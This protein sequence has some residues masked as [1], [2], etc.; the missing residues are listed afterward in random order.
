MPLTKAATSRVIG[1]WSGDVEKAFASTLVLTASV[2]LLNT[3]YRKKRKE[4]DKVTMGVLQFEGQSG[5]ANSGSAFSTDTL[6]SFRRKYLIVHCLASFADLI[7]V[8]RDMN[9]IE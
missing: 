2:E 8:I 5:P 6:S 9:S 4:Y 7:Q 1:F 3:L